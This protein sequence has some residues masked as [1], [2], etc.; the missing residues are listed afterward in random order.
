MK[1]FTFAFPQSFL[2]N[3]TNT[4]T[5]QSL[6]GPDDASALAS[7]RLTY[8]HLL[9]ADNGA[10]EVMLPGGRAATVSGFAAGNVR[11]ID[12]TDAQ[13]PIELETTIAPTTGGEFAATFTP[14]L[15]G[16]RAVLVTHESRILGASGQILVP[17]T[18]FERQGFVPNVVFP[19]GIVE[20]G[21]TALVYYGAADTS[22]AAVEFSLREIMELMNIVS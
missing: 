7:T 22:T 3:G 13:H 18:D 5:M 10:L 4:L 21:E 8:Q 2:A 11:A 12:I 15:N 1:T 14:S 19:T 17:E 20:Q 16:P 6:S 9:R